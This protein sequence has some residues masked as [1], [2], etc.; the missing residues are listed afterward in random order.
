MFPTLRP[1]NGLI[2]FNRQ[3]KRC[4]YDL[5]CWRA[6]VEK[7]SMP[8]SMARGFAMLDADDGAGWELA[9]VRLAA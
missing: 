2:Q 3:L 5:D 1:D 7:R 9:K 8:D 4:D 6:S